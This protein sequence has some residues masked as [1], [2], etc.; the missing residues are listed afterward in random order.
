[1]SLPEGNIGAAGVQTKPVSKL[2]ILVVVRMGCDFGRL[3]I[4]T[5]NNNMKVS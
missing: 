4:P 5:V 2:G 3:L 1:M